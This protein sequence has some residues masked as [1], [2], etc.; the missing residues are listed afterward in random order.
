METEICFAERKKQKLVEMDR[1]NIMNNN[2][3]DLI[4]KLDYNGKLEI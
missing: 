1:Q 4:K 3:N 2:L